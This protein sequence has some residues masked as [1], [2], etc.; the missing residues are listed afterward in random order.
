VLHQPDFNFNASTIVVQVRD[1]LEN[2]YYHYQ[3][4]DTDATVQEIQYVSLC[5][6]YIEGC[7][8]LADQIFELGRLEVCSCLQLI[9]RVSIN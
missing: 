2:S 7:A 8:C 6:H 5:L 1:F 3:G 9:G 4:L